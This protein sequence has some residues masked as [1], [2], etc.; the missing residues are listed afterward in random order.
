MEKKKVALIGS[1]SF[2]VS[3]LAPFLKSDEYLLSFFGRKPNADFPNAEFHLFDYP[4]APL[5]FEMLL[6]KDIIVFASSLGVQHGQN[7]PAD[8]IYDVNA[9]LPSKLLLYLENNNFKG[10]IFTFGSYAEIGKNALENTSFSEEEL[11]NST[12]PV[13]NA[14][15]GSKRVLSHF[16]HNNSFSFPYYH[17]IL[18]TIYGPGE[19]KNRLIPYLINGIKNNKEMSLTQGEQIRQY[20]YIEELSKL[21]IEIIKTLPASGIYNVF[22]AETLKIKEVIEKIFS[23]LNGNKNLIQPNTTREDVAMKSLIL[24]AS[25]LEKI[26]SFK[27]SVLIEDSIEKYN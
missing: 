26:I 22:A 25:K 11:L 12:F 9:F 15:A 8:H 23:R 7:D 14:Y 3:N 5:N 13:A 21:I 17:L 16:I 18:P 4:Q 6:Q 1:T 27:P 10:G 24:N 2:L 20:I 19:N